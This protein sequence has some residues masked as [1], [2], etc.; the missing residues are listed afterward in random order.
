MDIAADGSVW[1]LAA[2]DAAAV[3]REGGF[4]DD[5]T[6]D[7]YVITPEAVSR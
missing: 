1:V 5:Q 4:P 2:D 7:L 6:W 3:P